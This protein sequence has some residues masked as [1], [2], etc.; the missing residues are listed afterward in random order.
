MGPVILGVI[1]WS[2][3]DLKHTLVGVEKRLSSIESL[4]GVKVIST[5]LDQLDSAAV[6]KK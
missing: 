2:H 3:L 4:L 1:T 5:R 6:V